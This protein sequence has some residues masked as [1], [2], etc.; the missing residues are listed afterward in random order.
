[1]QPF[2]FFV[3]AILSL[4]AIGALFAWVAHK[5]TLRMKQESRNRKQ[6]LK[7]ERSGQRRDKKSPT[8]GAEKP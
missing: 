7:L 8:N 3:V 5:E 4:L 6:R 1:M 2:H